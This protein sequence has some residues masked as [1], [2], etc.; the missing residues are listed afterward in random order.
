MQRQLMSRT[1]LPIA[2]VFFF[3]AI[4]TSCKRTDVEICHSCTIARKSIK[5]ETC[6]NQEFWTGDLL[7]KKRVEC[8]LEYG[9][10]K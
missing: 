9:V 4:T 6:G 8:E 5:V 10:F 7:L 3:A 1:I 2:L